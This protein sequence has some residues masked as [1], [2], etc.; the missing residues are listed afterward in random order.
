MPAHKIT[1]KYNLE[2][3]TD[4]KWRLQA[5]VSETENMTEK[6]FVYQRKVDVPYAETPRDVFVNV[7]QPSDLADYPEDAPNDLFPYFRQYSLD[8]S[9][10]SALLASESITNIG[11]DVRDLCKA[12]DR[13]D[14]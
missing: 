8:L 2:L 14:P 4:G 10:D 1:V 6:I 3:L 9:I 13:I 7:A 5:W 12:M 11:A